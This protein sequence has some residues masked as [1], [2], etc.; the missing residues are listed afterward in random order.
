MDGGQLNRVSSFKYLGVVLDEKW[1][2]KPHVNSLV[3][4]LCCKN[5]DRLSVFNQI[6]HKLNNKTLIAYIKVSW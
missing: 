1:N 6:S 2:W 5:Y 3:Q 4:K